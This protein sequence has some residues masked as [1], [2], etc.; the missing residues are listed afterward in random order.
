MS[1]PA[2]Y[3]QTAVKYLMQYLKSIKNLAI[4]YKPENLF[5]IDYFNIDY[6]ADKSN[7][8]SILEII[9]LFAEGAI[10]WLNRK[11]QSVATSITEA[12]Y[13][14]MSICAKQTIWLAQLFRDIGYIQY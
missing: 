14:S 10:S 13:I 8:K 5:L 4:R 3:Y 11:Q 9:F 7:R 6:M 2:K 1:D 12:E